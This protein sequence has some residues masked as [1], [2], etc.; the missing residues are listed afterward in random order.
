MKY[1]ERERCTRAIKHARAPS[2]T[3]TSS[4]LLTALTRPSTV[5]PSRVHAMPSASEP[6]PAE[7]EAPDKEEE[8]LPAE[9]GA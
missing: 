1:V 2:A 7:E 5:G 6:E 3:A 4:A 9:Q 8:K